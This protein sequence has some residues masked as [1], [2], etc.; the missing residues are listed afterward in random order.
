MS[1]FCCRRVTRSALELLRFDPNPDTNIKDFYYCFIILIAIEF[2]IKFSLESGTVV[3]ILS[4]IGKIV[5]IGI[6]FNDRNRIAAIATH[7]LL[8]AKLQLIAQPTKKVTSKRRNAERGNWKWFSFF[9][10]KRW[11]LA[12]SCG[13]G[14]WYSSGEMYTAYAFVRQ[15]P[16]ATST[17]ITLAAGPSFNLHRMDSKYVI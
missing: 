13:A 17:F 15:L 8:G 9:I 6:G 16:A 4:N 14:G 1:P 11:P 12:A 7:W 10:E 3:L 2:G 5:R